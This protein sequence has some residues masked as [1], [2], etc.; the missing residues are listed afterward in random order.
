M[1]K[2]FPASNTSVDVVAREA[3]KEAARRAGV[4]LGEYLNR[5]IAEQATELGFEPHDPDA[6]AR[7]Q[8]LTARLMRPP[9]AGLRPHPRTRPGRD[10]ELWRTRG[11]S[12][13]K[14]ALQIT[15][16]RS[17]A[18]DDYLAPDVLSDLT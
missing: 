17:P 2:A 18:R 9:T 3:A 16:D 7:L 11:G 5:V 14:T 8:A 12:L 4:T 1:I 6:T 15:D 10:R 13:E